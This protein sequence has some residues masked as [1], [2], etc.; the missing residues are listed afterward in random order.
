M[1]ATGPAGY[2]YIHSFSIFTFKKKTRRMNCSLFPTLFYPFHSGT[3]IAR[4]INIKARE[5]LGNFDF[6]QLFVCRDV[7]AS[8][9]QQE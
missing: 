2:K 8:S 7:L 6:L 5:S 4:V 1:S 3:E 9:I